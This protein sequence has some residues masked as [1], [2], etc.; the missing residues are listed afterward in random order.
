LRQQAS[1][2]EVRRSAAEVLGHGNH[3]PPSDCGHL[4]Q[5]QVSDVGTNPAHGACSPLRQ[6]TV[7]LVTRAAHRA[8]PHHRNTEHH[9]TTVTWSVGDVQRVACCCGCGVAM[10]SRDTVTV[11]QGGHVTV[12]RR[13][14]EWQ[15][16]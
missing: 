4:V 1:N 13:R 9:H 8:P 11:V 10:E 7:G 16:R 15:T 5:P 3:G 12:M 6:L 2:G 14:C